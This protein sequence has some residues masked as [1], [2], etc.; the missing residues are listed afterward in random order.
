MA[1]AAI[2]GIAG[3]DDGAG[4]LQPVDV[5]PALTAPGDGVRPTLGF[6]A[7]APEVLD[8]LLQVAEVML[9]SIEFV[10]Y[11]GT[12]LGMAPTIT[13]WIALNQSAYEYLLPNT[14]TTAFGP[15]LVGRARCSSLAPASS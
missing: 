7:G 12:M 3:V 11:E 6:G 2:S 13:P 1:S 15:K 8:G 10:M 4:E 5:A 14:Q 9:S